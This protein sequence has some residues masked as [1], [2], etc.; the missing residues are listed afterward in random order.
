[1]TN[2][3]PPMKMMKKISRV[4]IAALALEACAPPAQPAAQ[5]TTASIVLGA[6]TH[7]W[8]LP[9]SLREISGL[10]VAPD[11]R[12]FAHNDEVAVIYEID[13]RD[14]RLV[15]AF[16]LGQP[17]QAGDFEG[18]AIA[19]D[20]VFWMTTS[21]GQIYSFREG[22][23]GAGVAFQT[24]DT[25]LSGACEVEGLAYLATD[26]SLILACKRNEA[27][28]MRDE[29][30]LYAWRPGETATHVWATL[31][32]ADITAHAGVRRFRPSSL[33]I[34]ARTG[35]I[36]LLSAFDGAVVEL[37]PHGELV[38]AAALTGEHVQA[39]GVAMLNDGSVVIADEAG[40]R[41]RR[42]L[43]SVYPGFGR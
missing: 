36:L 39:E 22:A 33:D 9:E 20:G 1:M 17:V 5:Q 28:A 26:Q 37:G 14:G 13:P 6:P 8:R 42:A 4:A 24:F 16:A 19:P 31:P 43:L 15:K 27:R 2:T 32:E 7:Q 34:D 41:G 10:A 40:G 29:I 23:D 12:L 35:R 18:L 11:G 25:S 38:N 3:A 30:V 21:Q